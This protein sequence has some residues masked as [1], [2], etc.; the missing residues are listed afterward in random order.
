MLGS[1]ITINVGTIADPDDKVIPL[2]NNDGY[3]GEYRLTES[4]RTHTVLV[5]HSTDKAT[6][7]GRK[8]DRHVVTYR[9]FVHPTEIYP[10]GYTKEAYTVFRIPSG[11]PLSGVSDVINGVLNTMI[12]D[13]IQ[14]KVINWES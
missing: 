5:R 8:M 7:N 9:Q 11:E 3:S 1:T 6:V 4:D 14:A 10:L 12:D 13:A 2:I